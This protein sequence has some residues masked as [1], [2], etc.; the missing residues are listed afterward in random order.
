M[1]IVDGVITNDSDAFLYGAKKVYR[2][3]TI[4]SGSGTVDVFDM[5]HIEKRL[6]LTREKLIAMSLLCGCDYDGTGVH[7][8]G[9]EQSLKYLSNFRGDILDR[10]RELKNDRV[11]F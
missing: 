9:P 6:N 7:G 2:N 5:L 1:Q 3:F 8:I 11:P 10:F 4:N